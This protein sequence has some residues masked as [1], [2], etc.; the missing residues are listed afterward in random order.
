[1]TTD[2]ASWRLVA[3][4]TATC[5]VEKCRL[6]GPPSGLGG[7]ARP[8]VVAPGESAAVRFRREF[9]GILRIG[10]PG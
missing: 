6:A 10:L 9:R 3:V 7:L 2:N 5:R 8:S 1:M 4:A